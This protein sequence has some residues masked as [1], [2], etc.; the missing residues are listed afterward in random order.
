VNAAFGPGRA[1]ST[2]RF[3]IRA[4]TAPLIAAYKVAV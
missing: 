4:M 1:A 2:N 3:E